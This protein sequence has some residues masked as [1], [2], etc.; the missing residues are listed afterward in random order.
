MCWIGQRIGRVVF[1]GLALCL[2]NSFSSYAA[3]LPQ[4]EEA[5]IEKMRMLTTSLKNHYAVIGTYP[6]A[7]DWGDLSPGAEAGKARW[8]PNRSGVMTLRGFMPV[9]GYEFTYNALT[10]GSRYTIQAV[11]ITLAFPIYTADEGQKSRMR[12]LYTDETGVIRHCIPQSFPDYVAGADDQPIDKEAQ[13]CRTSPA[14]AVPAFI[15]ALDNDDDRLNAILAL[16]GIGPVAAPA[17]PRLLDLLAHVLSIEDPHQA[18]QEESSYIID[19]LGKIGSQAASAIPL[20]RSAL[21]HKVSNIRYF[22]AHALGEMGPQ[23]QVAIP[24]LEG[25]LGDKEAVLLYRYPYGKD[26]GET[27]AQSLEKLRG[28]RLTAPAGAAAR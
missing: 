14:P 9:G 23:A 28:S 5:A 3:R 6:N 12:L 13:V 26:V 10:G 1:L 22:A 25:H 16:G 15:K 4:D 8:W 2:T 19:T 24:D 7:P 20:L 11:P 18:E 27:A 21:K 17:V